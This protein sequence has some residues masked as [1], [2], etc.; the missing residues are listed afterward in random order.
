[1]LSKTPTCQT[2]SKR[3]DIKRNITLENVN[4]RY[5]YMYVCTV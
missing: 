5:I 2:L 4:E 3:E 1:M